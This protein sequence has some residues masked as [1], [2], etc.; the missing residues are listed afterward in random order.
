MCKLEGCLEAVALDMLV[1]ISVSRIG[2]E[3]GTM[4]CNAIGVYISSP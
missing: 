1:R 3:E 2:D 4:E